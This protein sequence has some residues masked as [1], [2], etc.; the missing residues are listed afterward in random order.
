MSSNCTFEI[1]CPKIIN[2]ISTNGFVNSVVIHDQTNQVT[3]NASEGEI[4]ILDNREN[5]ENEDGRLLFGN[6]II[7]ATSGSGPT[8]IKD[9]NFKNFAY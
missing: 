3:Y 5:R 1:S 2:D 9:G 8:I 6:F 4:N 7:T